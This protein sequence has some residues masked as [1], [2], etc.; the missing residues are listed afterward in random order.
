MSVRIMLM[1]CW[2][3]IYLHHAPRLQAGESTAGARR[4]PSLVFHETAAE[5]FN[6][7]ML[8]QPYPFLPC[9]L[10]FVCHF[11]QLIKNCSFIRVDICLHFLETNQVNNEILLQRC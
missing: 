4:K 7:N 3:P 8:S 11:L 2:V 9:P 5:P 10:L 1:K 6:A